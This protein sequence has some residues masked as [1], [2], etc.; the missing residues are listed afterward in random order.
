M[1]KFIVCWDVETTGLNP[2]ED[3]ILQLAA[4]KFA[5]DTFERIESKKW[6][7]KPAHNYTISPQAQA[8]HGLTKEFIDANGIYFK[9]V[10]SEFFKMIEDADL[11]T[12]NGN[13]FDIKFLNEECKR[14]N[15]QLPITGKKFYDSFA[16]ECRFTPRNLSAVYKN[17]T[18]EELQDAHDALADVNATVTV[19]QKQFEKHE[20]T[21]DMID[22]WTE[23]N[24]L[25]PDGTIRNAGAPGD[26]L[27]I[28]FAVGKYK[29]S[30]FMQVAKTDPGYIKWYMENLASDY[31]KS[32]LANYYRLHRNDPS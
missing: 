13:S 1:N 4:T 8:V 7:I 11:L 21:Y 6:Y 28:V 5:K 2:K 16:M 23:N 24:L 14:W 12:Y 25:T 18:G 32:V 26:D 20:L 22:T 31:T 17:Y 15:L 9:E 19:F 30:E 10:A 3:F 27:V 29:D